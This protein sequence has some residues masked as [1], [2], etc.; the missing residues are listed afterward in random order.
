M[1]CEH[2]D[3]EF[4]PTQNPKGGWRGAGLYSECYENRGRSICRGL[5]A[6][7]TRQLGELKVWGDSPVLEKQ[8]GVIDSCELPWEAGKGSRV[9]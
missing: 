9:H 1:S 3:F 6:S 5:L 8:S 4:V 2:E 7:L